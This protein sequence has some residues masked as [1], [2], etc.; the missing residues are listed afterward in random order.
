MTEE[1]ADAA[2]LY[3]LDQEH[4][5]LEAYY[6]KE[7]RKFGATKH[8]ASRCLDTCYTTY[9]APG[10]VR[11]VLTFETASAA[12]AFALETQLK[13]LLKETPALAPHIKE[14]KEFVRMSVADF[15][16][17]VRAVARA[18][19]IAL[20]DVSHA[21][22]YAAPVVK[23]QKKR[24]REPSL[25]AEVGRARYQELADV[26][27]RIHHHN[28]KEDAIAFS[29]DDFHLFLE[30]HAKGRHGYL[31]DNNVAQV[32]RAIHKLMAGEGQTANLWRATFR[33]GAPVTLHEDLEA[34]KAE[35]VAFTHAHGVDPHDPRLPPLDDAS[36]PE[37][38]RAAKRGCGYDRSN[39]WTLTHPLQ[40]L[41]EY[42]E[43]KT[44]VAQTP[45]QKQNM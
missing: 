15:E 43:W 8:L 37:R 17:L 23:K 7:T 21:P 6:G 4:S 10:S 28:Q 30:S 42:K 29:K 16:T 39:G 31:S 19:G 40:K 32:E 38:K 5:H 41:I 12:D 13:R 44:R 26:V 11:Y 33:P 24:A 9:A 20:C 34:L 27:A 45:V 2:G 18:S 14:Q 22:R 25:G 3:L 35:A 36:P 1:R